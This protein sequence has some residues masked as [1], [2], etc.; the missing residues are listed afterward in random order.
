[1]VLDEET[2]R[3]TTSPMTYGTTYSLAITEV[4]DRAAAANRVASGT[5]LTFIA[6]EYVPTDIG[7]TGGST[8]IVPGGFDITGLG[9]DMAGTPISVISLIRSAPAI[10]ICA[11]AWLGLSAAILSSQ[12]GLMVRETLG[13]R[14]PQCGSIRF[15]GAI[16]LL[17][18]FAFHRRVGQAG[19]R[20]TRWVSRELPRDLAALAPKRQSLDWLRKFRWIAW[21]AFGTVTQTLPATV[22]FGMAVASR[23]TNGLAVAKFRNLEGVRSATAFT[24]PQRT[25]R[26]ALRI[27]GTGLVFSEVMFHPPDARMAHGSNLSS[28]TMAKALFVDLTGWRLAGAVHYTFPDGFKLEAGAIRG[29]GPGPSS[30]GSES[31][32]LLACSDPYAGQLNNAGEALK[33]LN[34][35]GAVSPGNGFSPTAPWPVA[36]DGLGHSLVLTV[37]VT[38]STIRGPGARANASAGRLGRW[39]RSA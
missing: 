15:L 14:R 11:C 29:G 24:T 26:W 4:C 32:G 21:Q 22:Y 39:M 16:G 36:A 35:A 2:V 23:N 17:H 31:T 1:M 9:N 8:A 25:N 37:R 19:G 20:P 13:P 18:G 38:G 10:L 34:P 27:G 30:G 33:L 28:S 7:S 12:A 3:L 6:T 5:M